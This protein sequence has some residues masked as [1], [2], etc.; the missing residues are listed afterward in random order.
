MASDQKSKKKRYVKSPS[1][2]DCNF[3]LKDQLEPQ[4]T[5]GPDPKKTFEEL[6][7]FRNRTPKMDDDGF[8][9]IFP[10]TEHCILR[11]NHKNGSRHFISI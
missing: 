8:K 5:G 11:V 6:R 3:P 7:F 1:D 2:I 4:L 10:G 9:K